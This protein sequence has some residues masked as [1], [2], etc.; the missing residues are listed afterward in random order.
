M[1]IASAEQHKQLIQLELKVARA[2][3]AKMAPMPLPLEVLKLQQ[4]LLSTQF[5]DTDDVHDLVSRNETLSGDVVALANRLKVKG[6]LLPPVQSIR[7]ALMRLGTERLK[8]IVLSMTMKMGMTNKGPSEITTNSLDVANICSELAPY[9]GIESDEAYLL[10][11]FHNIG[12][13]MMNEYDPEYGKYFYESMN[14]P[15]GTYHK[16]ER[17]Y[18][19]T[20]TYIG[21]LVAEQWHLSIETQKVILYHH[22]P[23]TQLHNPKLK[24]LVAM[25][26]L[27]N[28]LVCETSFGHYIGEE[29]KEMFKMAQETLLVP[30]EVIHDLRISLLSGAFDANDD[31]LK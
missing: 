6:N 17:H 21:L 1:T 22:H 23:L 27:A 15:F 5:P 14:L 9:A 3:F 16:E 11:L 31:P 29:L 2:L 13:L 18:H 24:R 26:Q 8:N 20:H 10:G 12:A 28:A 4:L 19:T 30:N 7:E 25:V